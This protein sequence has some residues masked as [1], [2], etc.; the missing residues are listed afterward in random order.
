MAEPRIPKAAWVSLAM[1]FCMYA[2]QYIDRTVLSLVIEPLKHEFA[3]SDSQLGFLSGLAFGIPY[4]LAAIPMGILADR[5]IRTRLLAALLTAWS[6]ATAATG[7]ATG[8]MGLVI[9]RMAL[10]IPEAGANPTAM[11]LIG[12]LF[13]QRWRNLAV[14]IYLSAAG[15]GAVLCFAV[16]GIVVAN[17]GWRYAFITA[18]IP[19]FLLAVYA[20]FIMK[21]PARGG[22]DDQPVAATAAPSIVS[23]LRFIRSQRALVHV[24]VALTLCAAAVSSFLIWMSA[25]FMRT[26]DLP[27]Q[28]VGL[29]VAFGPQVGCLLS[30]F[31]GNL[32]CEMFAKQDLRKGLLVIACTS[33][34]T[35]PLGLS[36]LGA[37]TVVTAMVAIICW[38]LFASCY[39]G[40]G[41]SLAITLVPPVMRGKTYAILSIATILV[42]YSLAPFVV[43]VIS[44]YAGLRQALMLPP[45]L[46]GW[47]ALHYWL[48]SRRVQT[49]LEAVQK[50]RIFS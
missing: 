46:C 35:M 30:P 48:A 42:G 1:L 2:T 43:G 36:L 44:D 18:S 19:G 3:L 33:F 16:G 27:I 32:L 22:T 47:G 34:V 15:F 39:T 9:A 28:Q 4:A 29:M 5:M 13:R 24:I 17:W 21:E 40:L 8:F 20:L 50:V 23:T 49:D 31:I 7:L 38:S 12:D 11:S 25:Y 45:L 26:F 10:A 6:L 41:N 14:T 37:S